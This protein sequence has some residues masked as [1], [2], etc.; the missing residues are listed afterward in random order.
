MHLAPRLK[1]SL[2][3]LGNKTYN[4]PEFKKQLMCGAKAFKLNAAQTAEFLGVAEMTRGVIVNSCGTLL[5]L[6]KKDVFGPKF[7]TSAQKVMCTTPTTSE[8]FTQD[9]FLQLWSNWFL[10]YAGMG[11]GFGAGTYFDLGVP[12]S[13]IMKITGPTT[14]AT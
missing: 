9:A 4:N 2:P 6:V 13:T 10:C 12:V 1:W 5:M 14:S 3:L 8:C 11:L 7:T